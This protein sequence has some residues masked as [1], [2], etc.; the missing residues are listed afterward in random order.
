MVTSEVRNG[1]LYVLC[2][3]ELAEFLVFNSR[4]TV[5]FGSYNRPAIKVSKDN[6]NLCLEIVKKAEYTSDCNFVIELELPSLEIKTTEYSN[7]V[8]VSVNSNPKY[9]RY[10][11][12]ISF[13]EADVWRE[14][15]IERRL[16]KLGSYQELEKVRE[17]VDELIKSLPL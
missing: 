13:D 4:Y 6:F 3:E 8:K 9:G 5:L 14:K 16:E 2:F 10:F 11:N 15:E 1:K 17:E 7:E 12:G